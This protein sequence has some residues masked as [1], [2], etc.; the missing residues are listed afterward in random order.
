[1][2]NEAHKHSFTPPALTLTGAQ[3]LMP[4]GLISQSVSLSDGQ[5]IAGPVGREVDLSGCLILPGVV[6]IH[7]DG[8]ERHMA[9]RRGAMQDAKGG[10]IATAA[11]M[12]ANGITTG[13]MAQFFS[14]EGGMR[15]P[16]F[17][18]HVFETVQKISADLATDLRLQLRLETH[19]LD[20]FDL[21]VETVDRFGIKYVVYNDHLQHDRLASGRRPKRL[22]G[23]ALK[24]GRN[25]EDHFAMMIG[26]HQRG[27]D[28]PAAL[29]A[30]S[31]KLLARGVVLGSHD[32]S[33]LS[34]R[35]KWSA[36]GVT[37]SEFPE[38][39]EAAEAASGSSA[40]VI[41]GAPNVVRGSSHAG[42]VSAMELIEAGLCDALASD[43]HYPALRAAVDSIVSKGVMDL[44]AAWRLVSTNPAKIL[45][46]TDRGQIAPGM[47]GDLL[48][49]E[50]ETGRVGATIAA[51]TLTYATGIVGNRFLNAT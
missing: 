23:Q 38:T 34:D 21:V 7:G 35:A 13:V 24:G 14:W 15:G 31:E 32:D 3:V 12:S 26:L 10:V 30:L 36:M 4:D 1:M 19:L 51:G 18:V 47:R 44:P 2:Q 5:I 29:T 17:A 37:I 33:T 39:F 27:P 6:D 8:F 43:Y 40:P 46:L 50:P 48:I 42:N 20:A 41:L 25:P 9:P 49:L 11:E 22:T 45:G 16:E 28:V